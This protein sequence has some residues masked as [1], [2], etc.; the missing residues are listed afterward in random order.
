MRSITISRPTPAFILAIVALFVALG[1]T[2]Y[3][4]ASLSGKSVR[5]NSLPANRVVANTLGGAQINES[6]LGVVPSAQ[7]AQEAVTA[8]S[9]DTA[10]TADT[11]KAADTAKTADTATALQGRGPGA[12][13]ANTV[14]VATNQTGEIPGPAGGFPADVAVACNANE[15]AIGGGGAWLIPTSLD[16][17]ALDAP[18][19]ATLPVQAPSGE[20]TGWRAAGRNFSGVNRILR[21]YAL[22]VPKNA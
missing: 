4:A 19:T 6:R 21:V 8:K 5:P 1:G 17:T 2:G 20:L 10:K 12:F 16:P 22:C 9:A 11:A 13:L 3:A 7:L 15:K 18:I 14:R